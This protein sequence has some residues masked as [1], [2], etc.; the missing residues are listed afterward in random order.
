MIFCN[1]LRKYCKIF[2][3]AMKDALLRLL[4]NQFY[5]YVLELILYAYPYI[6]SYIIYTYIR[7]CMYIYIYIY[8]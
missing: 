2:H 7:V 6:L 4:I 5:N 3:K 8:I 1:K